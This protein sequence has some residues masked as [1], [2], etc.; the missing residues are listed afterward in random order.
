MSKR[1]GIVVASVLLL[2]APAMA[3]D[4]E[5]VNARLYGFEREVA[6]GGRAH[7]TY[8]SMVGLGVVG[9]AVMFINAKRSHLD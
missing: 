6:L 8:L 7:L 1:L 4:D 3:Q 9:L 5:I 2:A